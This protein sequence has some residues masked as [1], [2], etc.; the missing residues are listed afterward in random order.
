MQ[1]SN[2]LHEPAETTPECLE[3]ENVDMEEVGGNR[4]KWGISADLGSSCPGRCPE[5]DQ[6]RGCGWFLRLSLAG[7]V[8]TFSLH[9]T[10]HYYHGKPHS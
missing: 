1:I 10:T 4:L 8:P 6:S 3:A 9:N 5:P 7:L 2:G